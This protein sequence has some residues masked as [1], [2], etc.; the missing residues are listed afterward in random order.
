MKPQPNPRKNYVID[1]GQ[2]MGSR[3]TA[4]GEENPQYRVKRTLNT[5]S[6]ISYICGGD[7]APY[8]IEEMKARVK[9]AGWY[10]F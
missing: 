10:G 5:F 6:I 8:V 2:F 3:C 9:I 7:C 4:C 1:E